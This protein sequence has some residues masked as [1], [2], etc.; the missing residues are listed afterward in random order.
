MAVILNFRKDYYVYGNVSNNLI[1][2][3]PIFSIELNFELS[4]AFNANEILNELLF[5]NLN[6]FFEKQPSF[7]EGTIIPFILLLLYLLVKNN[8]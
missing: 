7:L 4:T 6:N 2:H 1:Q 8:C 3:C 5:I